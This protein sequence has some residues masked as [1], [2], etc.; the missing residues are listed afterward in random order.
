MLDWIYQR[1]ETYGERIACFEANRCWSYKDLLEEIKRCT[2][3]L[4]GIAAKEPSVIVIPQEETLFSLAALFAVAHAKHIA[5]PMSAE[6]PT[7][8]QN[9][10]QGSAEATFIFS[11]KSL[12]K[13]KPPVY[14]SNA[15]DLLAAHKYSGLIL[16]S[17]GTTGKPK[18]VLHNLDTFLNRYRTV[19]PRSDRTIQLLP[20][21]HMGGL[22]AALRTLFAG[23]ALVVPTARTP[24]AVGEVI[25]RYQASILPA[26]P[27]FLNL[28]LLANVPETYDC[29]SLEVIAYGAEPMQE[30]LLQRLVNQ[31]P[32]VDFQQKFGTSETGA[33]RIKSERNDS[34]YFRIEDSGV[35]WRVVNE[36]LWLKTSS[37]TLGYLN[38]EKNPFEADGW[39][40]TGDLVH[41]AENGA[42][43]IIG[44]Q[45]EWINVGGQK[46]HPSEIETVIAELEDV[47]ACKVFDKPDAIL[48]TSIA[49]TII[50]RSEHD[51]R[52]WKRKI[53]THCRDRIASWKIPTSVELSAELSLNS[54]LK[55][56]A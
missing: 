32:K 52:S 45:S 35:E 39:Y 9:E 8:E 23:S 36:E 24:L 26:S 27:S 19:C 49:C 11:K 38:S 48:G 16:F 4:T 30:H 33:I 43:R 15:E 18:G 5:L 51:L 17:S 13:L 7:A 41:Q 2:K 28:F 53:R 46:V 1:F 25:E 20:T 37:Q 50:T 40:R 55:R 47:D 3:Q 44:R 34:L 54:R 22:D 29:E 21:D 6:I 31:F 10:Q 56:K 14:R 42:L 12:R